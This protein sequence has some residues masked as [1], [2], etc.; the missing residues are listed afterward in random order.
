MH[1]AANLVFHK[2]TKHIEVEC[3]FVRSQVQSQVIHTVFSHNYNQLAD[4]FTKALPSA[5]F[6]RLLGKLGSINPFDPA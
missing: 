1:I 5:Q 6:H 2:R 3:H 4:L